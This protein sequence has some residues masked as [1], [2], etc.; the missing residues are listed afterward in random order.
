MRSVL[1]R[2]FRYGIAT[3]RCDRDVAGDLRGALTTPKTKHHAAI[4]DPNEVGVLLNTMDGYTV[5]AVARMA[6]RQIRDIRFSAVP[7]ASTGP[8]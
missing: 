5:Q 2:V 7:T 1:S 8:T 6:M 3:A 4:V